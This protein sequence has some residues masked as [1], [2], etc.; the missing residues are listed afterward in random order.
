MVEATVSFQQTQGQQN[1]I[2]F[3]EHVTADWLVSP[4]CIKG[5]SS[6]CCSMG[7]QAWKYNE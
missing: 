3:S 2:I 1:Y 5:V 4:A 6:V 7:G